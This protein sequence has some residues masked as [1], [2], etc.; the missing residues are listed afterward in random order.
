MDARIVYEEFTAQYED[1]CDEL[2]AQ[3]LLYTNKIRWEKDPV[4]R[5]VYNEIL[6][7]IDRELTVIEGW[8]DALSE[9]WLR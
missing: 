4:K 3:W 5:D 1:L 7:Y 8:F 2:H 9:R 6:D